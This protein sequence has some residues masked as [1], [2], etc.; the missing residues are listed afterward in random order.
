MKVSPLPRHTPSTGDAAGSPVHPGAG[1]LSLDGRGADVLVHP[2]PHG[3]GAA[4]RRGARRHAG[5]HRLPVGRNGQRTRAPRRPVVHI[6]SGLAGEPLHPRSRPAARW[7]PPARQRR[8]RLCGH[9]PNGHGHGPAPDWDA[10]PP[11]RQHGRLPERRVR[12]RAGP[13]V[14]QSAERGRRPVARRATPVLHVR[15]GPRDGRVRFRLRLCR[16]RTGP[17]LAGGPHRAGLPLRPRRG[18]LRAGAAPATAHA[19]A[20]SPGTGRHA[21]GR[22]GSA[23]AGADWR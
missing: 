6:V 13:A 7:G 18:A 20:R 3:A 22:R 10:S 4:C 9:P 8:G 15:G 1:A 14:D 16:G 11:H 23:R 17:P 21:L 5:Q 2:V 12:G 19:G